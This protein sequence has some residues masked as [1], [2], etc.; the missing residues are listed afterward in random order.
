MNIFSKF[1]EARGMAFEEIDERGISSAFLTDLPDGQEYA[2][3]LFVLLIEDEVS[4]YVRFT[5]VPFVEQPY[6][7]YSP[8]FYAAIGRR[9]HDL[10]Q[11][12]FAFDDDDDLELAVDI[13]EEQLDQDEFDRVLQ[14]LVDYASSS[15]LE[16]E[17]LVKR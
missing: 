16:I 13:P 4:K 17:A 8:G 6:D 2:F 1:F 3:N 5:I 9:N 10:P 14:L 7:G 15:Y 12:K 11:L